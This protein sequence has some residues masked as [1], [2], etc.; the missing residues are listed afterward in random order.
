MVEGR[1]MF[2]II[3]KLGVGFESYIFIIARLFIV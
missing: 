3:F 1:E 2:S